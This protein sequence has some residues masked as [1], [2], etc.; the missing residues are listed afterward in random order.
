M[1]PDTASSINPFRRAPRRPRTVDSM[2]ADSSL[3]RFVEDERF[4]EWTIS[5]FYLVN[6]EGK[7]FRVARH[8]LDKYTALRIAK[9]AT[10]LYGDFPE[11]SDITNDHLRVAAAMEQIGTRGD[12]FSVFASVYRNGSQTVLLL[13]YLR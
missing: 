1:L 8:G 12:L 4:A 3:P 6:A 2:A 11:L 7:R 10:V 5:G 13:D 9:D